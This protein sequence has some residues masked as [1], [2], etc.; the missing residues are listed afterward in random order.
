MAH[1]HNG[2]VGPPRC[3]ECNAPLNSDETPVGFSFR[4]LA[5]S[6]LPPRT[7]PV[8]HDQEKRPSPVP[9]CVGASKLLLFD[10][11]IPNSDVEPL[12]RP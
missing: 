4:A 2:R 7:Q 1:D 3:E 12:V 5:L 11:A 6:R 8:P 9:S 10:T